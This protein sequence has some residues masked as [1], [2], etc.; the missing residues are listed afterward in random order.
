MHYIIN[1]LVNISNN[2]IVYYEYIKVIN[3]LMQFILPTGNDLVF[4]R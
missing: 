1:N 2:N 4:R 3:K